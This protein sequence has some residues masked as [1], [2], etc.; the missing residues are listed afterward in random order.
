MGFKVPTK[1][2][3]FDDPE[4]AGLEIYTRGVKIGQMRQIASLADFGENMP[5]DEDLAPVFRALAG[6][7]HSW[8]LDDDDGDPITPSVAAVAD[9]PFE[10][11]MHIMN[12]LMAT[13]SVA[14]PLQQPSPD[15]S[16]SLA[17]SIPMEVLSESLSS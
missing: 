5:S 1:R 15:G 14:P 10:M 2:L 3:V 11:I 16:A 17:A 12:A 13:I 9:L 7:I 8:N 4:L 6:A